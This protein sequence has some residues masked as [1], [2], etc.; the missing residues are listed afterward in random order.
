MMV[1]V[2]RSDVFQVNNSSDS[3]QHNGTERWVPFGP[4][5]QRRYEFA[6][7]NAFIVAAVIVCVCVCDTVATPSSDETQSQQRR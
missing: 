5:A 6:R 3:R 4:A 1:D 7:R 2:A